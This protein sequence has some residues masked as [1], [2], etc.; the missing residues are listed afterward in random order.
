MN[1][2]LKLPNNSAPYVTVRKAGHLYEVLI[3]HPSI[4]LLDGVQA[5]RVRVWSELRDALDHGK[6]FATVTDRPFRIKGA[7][8]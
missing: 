3:V 4:P 5:E 2:I 6:L 7:S 8:R 1:N